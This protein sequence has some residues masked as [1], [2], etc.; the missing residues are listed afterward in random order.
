MHGTIFS[1]KR[2]QTPISSNTEH[3][4]L[5]FIRD[6]PSEDVEKPANER[7]NLIPDNLP[8]YSTTIASSYHTFTESYTLFFMNLGHQK[9]GTLGIFRDF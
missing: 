1:S 8:F 4:D 5:I 6:G 9:I 2:E 3:C 7:I